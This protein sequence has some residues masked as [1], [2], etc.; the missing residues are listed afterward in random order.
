MCKKMHIYIKK[1]A[2]MKDTAMVREEKFNPNLTKRTLFIS[3][4]GTFVMNERTE[5]KLQT[6]EI[7]ATK[8][9]CQGLAGLTWQKWK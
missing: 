4:A 2:V 8:L 6:E 5:L 3:G 7:Q 1:Q 9:V